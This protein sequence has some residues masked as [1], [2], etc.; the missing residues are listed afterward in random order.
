MSEGLNAGADEHRREEPLVDEHG[1]EPGPH[2]RAGGASVEARHQPD[3]V[4]LQG[5]DHG[6][7]VVSINT[8]VAVGKHEDRVLS[9]PAEVGDV[10]DLVVGSDD[11]IVDDES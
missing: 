11:P 6:T 3:R 2:T 9:L 10:A 1:R 7:E 4:V 8:H 5:R